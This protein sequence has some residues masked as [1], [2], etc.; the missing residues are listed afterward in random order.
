MFHDRLRAARIYRGL[1]LQKTADELGISLRTYQNYES[2]D[3]EPHLKLLT[4]IAEF[5]N[6]PTDFLLGR[7][8]Y[9]RSLGVHVDVPPEGPPRHPRPQKNPSVPCIR[10]ADTDVN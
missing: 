10:S 8:E 3:R 9:L 1:T 6:V 5:L 2:G 7:D 4:S